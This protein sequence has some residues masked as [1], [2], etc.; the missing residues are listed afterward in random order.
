MRP[1]AWPDA[2]RN[3]VE[4]GMHVN[5]FAYDLLP[6]SGVKLESAAACSTAMRT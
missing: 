1:G 4:S 6:P 3:I 5:V 2:G